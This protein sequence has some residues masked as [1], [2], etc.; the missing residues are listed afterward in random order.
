MCFKKHKHM[1]A[2]Q[3]VK[4]KWII[5]ICNQGAAYTEP[6]FHLKMC[7]LLLSLVPIH[8]NQTGRFIR[9]VAW[10]YN[11]NKQEQTRTYIILLL[12]SLVSACVCNICWQVATVSTN[13]ILYWSFQPVLLRFSLKKKKKNWPTQPDS[14]ICCWTD[15][16]SISTDTLE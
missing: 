8:H 16:F 2:N 10:K 4:E 5:N 12:F 7:F 9:T 11:L 1:L 14:N 6:V 15:V 3:H 13:T